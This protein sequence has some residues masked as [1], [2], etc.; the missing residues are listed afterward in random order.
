M[1]YGVKSSAKIEGDE[2]GSTPNIHS[3]E[4]VVNDLQERHL[5]QLELPVCRRERAEGWGDVWHH[6]C[7]V[8]T[9]EH[10]ADVV[11]V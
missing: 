3:L 7:Q 11:S 8:Q 2:N 9:L 10:L 5:R 6:P 1:V 4:H